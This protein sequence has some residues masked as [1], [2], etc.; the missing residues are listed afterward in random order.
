MLETGRRTYAFDGFQIDT[1]RRLLLREGEIVPLTSK[2]FELL[3]A[4]IES[5]GRELSKEELMQ[6]VWPDQIVEDANLTV[7]FYS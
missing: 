2:A 4:L 5:E 7:T 6:R 1:Q 3:L